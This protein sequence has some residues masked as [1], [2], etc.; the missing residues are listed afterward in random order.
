[1]PFTASLSTVNLARPSDTVRSCA[2]GMASGD[3]VGV[4]RHLG[5][6]EVPQLRERARL[7]DLA[8]A[9]DADPVAQQLDL[10]EDVAGEQHGRARRA[11]PVD[12]RAGR[13]P[14]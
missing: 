13:R 1:M 5:A 6:G 8:G 14:P 3:V 4:E 9:D 10:G 2:P 11:E 7:D 12:L